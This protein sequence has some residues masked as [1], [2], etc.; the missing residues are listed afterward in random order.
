MK[1][2]EGK[3]NGILY[4]G[5]FDNFS[6]NGGF[7]MERREF[8]KNNPTIESEKRLNMAYLLLKNPQ[9]IEVMQKSSGHF[10]HGTNANVLPSILKYGIN[11]VDTS[12]ENNIA[13]ITG[14]EWSRIDGKRDF[15]SLTDCL[16]VALGYASKKPKDNNS[17]NELL[18]FG[19]VIGVSFE[20]MNDVSVDGVI[21]DIPEIGVIGNLPVDHIKFL[22]VSDDKVEFVKKMVGQKDIE[23]VSM[24]MRDLFFRRDFR[25]RLSILE[26]NE[27][28]IEPTKSPYPIYF[29]DDVKPLVNERKILKIKKIYEDL[30]AKICMNIKQTEDKNISERG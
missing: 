14:E 10:L 5:G 12:I 17:I 2:L 26:Q 13:V 16:D 27:E 7:H 11:S 30:K 29:K 21:S 3:W 18:N 25:E 20:N 9:M 15:V 23:V 24:N 22:V 8:L 1:I 19:V 4:E 6:V 28:N